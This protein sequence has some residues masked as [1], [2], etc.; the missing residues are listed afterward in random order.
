MEVDYSNMTVEEYLKAKA[1]F[2]EKV[3]LVNHFNPVRLS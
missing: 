1:E 2:V 3:Y